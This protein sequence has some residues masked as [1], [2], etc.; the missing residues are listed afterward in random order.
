V[1]AGPVPRWKKVVVAVIVLCVI[2]YVWTL[3]QR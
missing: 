2:G 1:I 3:Q